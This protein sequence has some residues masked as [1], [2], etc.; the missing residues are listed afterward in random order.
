MTDV[1]R[2]EKMR[3]TA[4][5]IWVLGAMLCAGCGTAESQAGGV[6]PKVSAAARVTDYAATSE[7]LRARAEALRRTMAA[8]PLNTSSA[9]AVIARVRSE[10]PEALR[11]TP[12]AAAVEGR[13]AKR[14]ALAAVGLLLE[15][16][17]SILGRWVKITHNPPL[18]VSAAQ[19][20]AAR[21]ASLQ[22]ADPRITNLARTLVEVEA[23]LFA[24]PPIGVCQMI[25]GWAVG[26]YKTYPGD[27][28]LVRPHGAVGQAWNRA[29]IAAGCRGLVRPT[30]AT[31]LAVLHPYERPG[32]WLTTR[33]IEKL[34]THLW[35]SFDTAER[36]HVETLRSVLGLPPPLRKWL[37]KKPATAPP[38]RDCMSLP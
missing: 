27:E 18:A 6:S 15:V 16:N 5:L 1:G 22:W 26:G 38:L 14:Q 30:Q 20:F 11:G 19:E 4:T 9:E 35:A 33:K 8:L 2:T 34:E 24:I 36:V 32:S 10:C 12:A 13:I 17:G 29:L 21:V 7:Y 3:L 31:L 28:E 25:R 23:Q 37:T